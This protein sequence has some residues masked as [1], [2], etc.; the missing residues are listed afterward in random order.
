M[1]R[2]FVPILTLHVKEKKFTNGGKN[3]K[4]SVA[5]GLIKPLNL[6]DGARVR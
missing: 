6:V 5:S 3:A 2:A 1:H 4:T